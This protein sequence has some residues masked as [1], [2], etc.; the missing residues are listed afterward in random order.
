MRAVVQD[1]YGDVDVLRLADIDRPV[2]RAGEVLVRVRA[3]GVHIGDWRLMRGLPLIIR[4]AYGLR[5]PRLRVRGE[6]LA[7]VVETVGP[8]VTAFR[9]GDE[10]V[11]T[12]TGSHAEYAV[13]RVD[14]LVARPPSLDWIEA[15]ALPTSSVTALQAVRDLGEVRPGQRLLLIG[16]TGGV[17]SYA[18]QLA[19]ALGAEVTA[20]CSAASAE[21]ARSLGAREVIDYTA[22]DPL[23]PAAGRRFD[24]VL[25][26]V[27]DRSIG[28]LRRV[29]T[30][31][32]TLVLVAP[33]PAT[34]GRWL[35]GVDRL[36][37]ASIGSRFVRQRLR[38]LASVD[39]AED[40]AEV[41]R[42]VE[43]GR[44]R[45]VVERTWPLDQ[46]AEAMRHI[47]RGHSHGK[48]VVTV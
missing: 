35:G 9:V 7:G 13:A 15:A 36:V 16:A 12:G 48:V 34:A 3:A 1:R 17:G 22:T 10:V 42:H 24:V 25:D 40:L 26:A 43:A 38:P 41:I 5:A 45:P 23:D 37:A 31:D 11:G 6:A 33:A 32:G 19:V 14:R 28:E 47:G 39:R 21:L 4:L 30:D 27:G 2:P 18:T 46:I 44:V 8:G 20:V 29:L